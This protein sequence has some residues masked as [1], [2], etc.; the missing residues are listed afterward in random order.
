MA[1]DMALAAAASAKKAV[2]SYEARSI[3]SLVF[4]RFAAGFAVVEAVGAKA[5]VELRLAVHT[6]FFAPTTRFWR[7][8]LGAGDF[9]P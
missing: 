3:R 6:E 2:I 9:F 8:A 7:L 4:A 1:K 5:Y